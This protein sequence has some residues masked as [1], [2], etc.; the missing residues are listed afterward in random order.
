MKFRHW[1][2]VWYAVWHRSG[3]YS[4]TYSSFSRC[5]HGS[6]GWDMMGC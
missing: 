3:T 1:A 5:F 6:M 4:G 2:V